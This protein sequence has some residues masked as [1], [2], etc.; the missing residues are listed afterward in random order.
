MDCPVKDMKLSPKSQLRYFLM[1][2]SFH[3][4]DQRFLFSETAHGSNSS[5]TED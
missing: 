2:N 4:I 5:G 1:M 3:R